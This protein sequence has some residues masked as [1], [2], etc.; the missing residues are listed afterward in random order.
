[1]FESCYS[2][3]MTCPKCSAESAAGAAECAKCGIIFAKWVARAN[4]AAAP[5]AGAGSSFGLIGLLLAAGAAGAVFFFVQRGASPAPR[6]KAALP[7]L[8]EPGA[9]LPPI[10]AAQIQQQLLDNAREVAEAQG[11]MTG[12]GIDPVVQKKI[13][14]AQEA[15]KAQDVMRLMQQQPTPQQLRAADQGDED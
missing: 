5:A 8:P 10:D 11:K 2:Q 14:D 15:L 1:M 9:E 7:S 13:S 6:P 12:E 3:G 4:A